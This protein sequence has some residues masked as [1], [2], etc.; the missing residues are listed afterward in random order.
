MWR[1]PR[2]PRLSETALTRPSKRLRGAVYAVAA[3]RC[4]EVTGAESAGSRRSGNVIHDRMIDRTD[5]LERPAAQVV[6]DLTAKFVNRQ[7]D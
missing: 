3:G 5:L 2:Y 4:T 6:N 1:K 7:M